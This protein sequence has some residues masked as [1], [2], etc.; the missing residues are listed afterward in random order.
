MLDKIQKL[1][2]QS[3]FQKINYWCDIHAEPLTTTS[4][5]IITSVT[6]YSNQFTVDAELLFP[7]PLTPEELTKVERRATL[8]IIMQPQNFPLPLVFR[9]HTIPHKTSSTPKSLSV[10]TSGFLSDIFSYNQLL[11]KFIYPEDVNRRKH[12]YF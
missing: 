2:D 3:E 7:F 4:T 8:D 9:F 5:K 11:N 1:F 10:H 12:S 6:P